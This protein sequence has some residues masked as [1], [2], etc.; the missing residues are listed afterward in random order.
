MDI[1]HE[2]NDEEITIDPKVKYI[3][4]FISEIIIYIF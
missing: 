1:I 4:Y 2:K 3:S